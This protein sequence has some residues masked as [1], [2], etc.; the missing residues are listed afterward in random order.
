MRAV[1]SKFLSLICSF[2]LLFL[3]WGAPA[4]A[5]T[6]PV[7]GLWWT[8]DKDAVVE[9]YPCKGQNFCGRFYWLKDD[10]AENPSLDDRNR[11]PI[12]SKRPLCGLTFLGGFQS[13]GGGRYEG[14]WLYSPRHSAMFSASLRL[15]ASDKLELRGFFILPFLGGGQTWQRAVSPPHCPLLNKP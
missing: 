12:L 3:E 13:E 9:I 4:Y 14:G 1:M 6:D 11:D 2:L 8:E 5:Q 7:E 10:S 15:I